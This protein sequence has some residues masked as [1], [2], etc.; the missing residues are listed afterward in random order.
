MRKLIFTAG[1]MFLNACVS[2][3]D[4]PAPI[5]PPVV[6]GNAIQS[7]DGALLGLK[8]WEA[9]TPRA[10]V[11]ALHGMNDY[12]R[13]YEGPATYWAKSSSITTYAYDQRGHGL[14]GPP[15][16]WQG[17]ET[18]KA[19]LRAVISAARASHP[20]LPTYVVGHSMGAAVVMAAEAQAPLE[21]DGLILA[22]PGVWGGRALPLPY[23]ISANL[24]AGFAP[25]KTLTGERAERQAT[26]NIEVLRE[27][28]RDP[29]VIKQTRLDAVVGV[30]RIMGEA[31]AAPEAVETPV[32]FLIGEKDEIIP[33]KKQANAAE[34][35]AAKTDIKR[36]PDGWHM[37]FRDLQAEI[38]WRDVAGW[39][40]ERITAANETNST[41]QRAN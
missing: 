26:D 14:T 28:W 9:E 21:V 4:A 32:L 8:R 5:A 23:R 38:V 41:N 30:I 25:G 15:G 2:F 35:L 7:I 39:I 10:I 1:A 20:G 11:I 19:D 33:V 16:R 36:Y 17:G 27:M 31:Y 6:A 3:P 37:L 24:A 22:A 18:M 29:L 12:S 40:G 34:R 13:M